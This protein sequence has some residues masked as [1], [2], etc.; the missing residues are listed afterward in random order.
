MPHT[1]WAVTIVGVQRARGFTL[2][3]I[4]VVLGIVIGM[5]FLASIGAS[6]FFSYRDGHDAG[7]AL[8][9]VKNAQRMYLSDNPKADLSEI[10]ADDLTPYLPNQAWPTLPKVGARVP[11]ISF[12]QYPPVAKLGGSVYDPSLKPDDGLWDAGK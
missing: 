6:Q 9:V 12:T 8:R 5:S 4:T 11:T 2:I 10:S 3:E 7:E 1:R